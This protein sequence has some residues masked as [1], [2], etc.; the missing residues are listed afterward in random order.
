MTQIACLLGSPRADGNSA[1]L[2]QR[3]CEAAEAEG[4]QITRFELTA[5]RYSGCRTLFHCK[6]TRDRCGLDDE[7]TPVLEAV[8]QADIVVLASPVYFTDVSSD[9]KACID[10]W[11]SFFVPDYV[12]NPQKSRLAAGKRLVFILTQGE[13]EERCADIF[14]RYE[15]PFGMLGFDACHLIRACAVRE[16]GAVRQQ[17]AVIEETETF[18]RQLLRGT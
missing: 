17:A 18:A 16:P 7:L 13:P 8:R 9:L 14:S 1:E 15:R 4:A 11:F 2:A 5:L 6:T 3:F 12:T 10:R